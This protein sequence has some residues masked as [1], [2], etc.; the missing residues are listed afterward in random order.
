[1]ANITKIAKFRVVKGAVDG[2][3]KRFVIMLT[4]SE[5]REISAFRH[6][7]QIGSQGEAARRLIKGGLRESAAAG[8]SLA[9]EP[10]A[11]E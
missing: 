9:T 8:A 5:F 10:A 2:R 7:N 1:M 4:E 3:T 6:A 11:A